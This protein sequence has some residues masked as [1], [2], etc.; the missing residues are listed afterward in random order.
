MMLVK[1]A[2]SQNSKIT[3]E[4]RYVLQQASCRCPQT[5]L[6]RQDQIAPTINNPKEN[7]SFRKKYLVGNEDSNIKF[8]A[9][10]RKTFQHLI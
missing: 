4:P 5:S 6:K 3:H 9:K 1:T 2:Y 10:A 8:L 7:L